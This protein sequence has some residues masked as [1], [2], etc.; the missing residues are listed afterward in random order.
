MLDVA[1]AALFCAWLACCLLVRRPASASA[2][3]RSSSLP[4]GPPRL[5]VVG[6]AHQVPFAHQHKTFAAWSLS[7]GPIIYA[8]FLST[9]IVI[10]S[11][12]QAAQDLLEKRGAIYSDRPHSV[13]LHDVIDYMPNPVWLP[14]SHQWRKQRRWY[15]SVLSPDVFQPLQ[16]RESLQLVAD[17]LR[18]PSAF[19]S[20]SKRYTAAMMMEVAYGRS[21]PSS[22]DGFLALVNSTLEG[23]AQLGGPAATVLD[24]MPFLRHIPTWSWFP[25]SS[26]KRHALCVRAGIQA[27]M[28]IPYQKVKTDMAAGKAK[29]SFLRMLIDGQP[30]ASTDEE[31]EMSC[32]ASMMYAAGSDTTVTVLLTFILAMVRHPRVFEKAQAEVDA[33]VGRARLPVFSDRA[34]MPYFECVLREVYRWNAPSRAGVPHRVMEDDEYAGYRIPRGVMVLPNVWMM[35]R[36]QDEYG[37]DVDQFRP[38]RFAEMSAEE[39]ERK[40]PRRLVFGFGRRCVLP[41]PLPHHTWR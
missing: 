16:H 5:P 39:M 2:A 33:V 13:L 40:D 34:A 24:F 32:A 22:H 10:L 3:S 14:Y 36:D 17:I 12:A 26:T 38:E 37:P 27:M 29:P 35:T 20:H 30:M 1:L 11:S 25:G 31:R 7:Y 21:V 41:R 28:D 6:N 19:I 8:Q 23:L 15:H 18:E 9:R 4:P